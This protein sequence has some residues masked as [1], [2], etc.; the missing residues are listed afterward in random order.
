MHLFAENRFITST[1]FSKVHLRLWG[2]PFAKSFE[3][4]VLPGRCCWS[5]EKRWSLLQYFCTQYCSYQ[6]F[7]GL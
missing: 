1:F 5:Y 4:L 6:Y 3:K 2:F 7:N